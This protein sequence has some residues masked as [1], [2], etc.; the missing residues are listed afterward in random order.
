MY[1]L[2]LPS[3]YLLLVR[4][5]CLDFDYLRQVHLGHFLGVLYIEKKNNSAWFYKH[6]KYSLDL[7]I[8]LTGKCIQLTHSL[9]YTI[10]YSGCTFIRVT[11]ESSSSSSSSL[12]LSS[13]ALFSSVQTNPN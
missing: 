12:S 9:C 6:F 3:T 13:L 4:K 10:A 8:V 2:F 5:V 11:L 7:D 1:P